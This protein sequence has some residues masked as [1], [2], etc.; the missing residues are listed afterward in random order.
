MTLSEGINKAIS[1]L[2]E[3]KIYGKECVSECPFCKS[4]K[5]KFYLNI[6][7]GLY[8]CKRASCG[9][10]SHINKLLEQLGV[11][12]RVTGEIEL[13]RDD[14]PKTINVESKVRQLEEDDDIVAYMIGRGIS[15]ETL[16][17]SGCM[18]RGQA[19][20]MPTYKDGEVVGV[21]YRTA[22][23]K[24]W[25]ESGS[26]QYL[27]NRSNLDK[28]NKRI[29]ITEGRCLSGDTEV[30]TQRGW[31]RLD[32]FNVNNDLVVQV[33]NDKTAEFVE[34]IAYIEN[35]KAQEIW[36]YKNRNY[37]FCGT[38]QHRVAA[39]DKYSGRV[40]I[41]ELQNMPNT[42]YNHIIPT[43]VTIDNDGIS[44][45]NDEIA[46][47]IA[48]QADGTIDYRK[49]GS[50]YIRISFKKDRKIKRF[51]EL[52]HRL[53]IRHIE[54][55]HVTG[56]TFF[57]FT[58][59]DYIY[60]KEFN[61]EWAY[62]MSLQ[63][64]KFFIDEMVHWDGNSVPNRNQVEYVST[65]KKNAE[66]MQ[67][68]AST[69]GYHSTIIV[70][71]RRDIGWNIAY[72]VS[73]LLSKKSISWQAMD[74]YKTIEKV[75]TVYC[76]QVPSGMILIRHNGKISVT[77]NCD[78][79][80]LVEMGYENVV[81]VPNGA[82]G[83]EWIDKEWKLLNEFKE[84]V[85]LYDNDK[86]GKQGFEEAKRRMDF[87]SIFT[88]NLGKYKDINEAYMAESN[89]LYEA[90]ESAKEIQLDGFVSLDGVTT[91]DGVGTELYSCG[92][93]QFDTIFGGVRMG[94]ST[95][96]VSSSGAGK[97]QPLT[98][99]LYTPNGE[100]T[101]G[102]IK[103]G[104]MVYGEDGLPHKVI[105]VFPQGK[106]RKVI[107]TFSDGSIAECCDEHLW[108]IITHSGAT[109]T[110][111]LKEIIEGGYLNK[112]F[113]KNQNKYINT[114][115]YR[116]P[117]TLPVKFV[118]QE[119]IISPYLLG[120]LIGDGYICNNIVAF[121]TNEDYIVEAVEKEL[122][123]LNDYIVKKYKGNNYTYVIKRKEFGANIIKRELNRMNISVKSYDKF[124]PDEY[125]YDSVENRL[126]LL[127][128]IYD[129]D[130]CTQKSRT[131]IHTTSYRLKDDIV[132]LCQSL[133]MTATVSED[134]REK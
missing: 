131:T 34:P 55:K 76:V 125:K 58:A 84:I 26:Q 10:H 13:K 25:Q 104:D 40:M 100:I 93:P 121:S 105:G 43:A 95:L 118:K 20:A 91:S 6:E 63:Q 133:G 92:I 66:F 117:V 62:K 98:S 38:P 119:H 19:L 17:E 7:T 101:M 124:I 56:Y 86:A 16:I 80:T 64:R 109:Y 47:N 115:K 132:W 14:K 97:A 129:T 37:S 9:A 74:K 57:G 112:Q 85:L 106:K 107:A 116:I 11:S 41:D 134:R 51:R 110:K 102:D 1:L 81:S 111:T 8:S 78:A 48:I 103:I 60:G 96:I 21:A 83:H 114:S 128:G 79:L 33:N 126:A 65:N 67:I 113:F 18:K 39:W 42:K 87:A 54:T 88:I 89:F 82:S 36:R 32:G 29:Y 53:N 31:V 99:K 94:E 61:I 27:W 35:K 127:R 44:L 68:I 15:Y 130:G 52:I 23:K 108:N 28:S 122:H 123:N 3:H 30:L 75:N 12:E 70:K 59:P 77:G 5:H 69:C 120:V 22:D 50:R 72:K 49:N 71:D 45:S 4:D 2:G 73:I 46:I 90:M 24:I